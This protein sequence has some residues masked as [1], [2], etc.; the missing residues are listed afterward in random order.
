MQQMDIQYKITYPGARLKSPKELSPGTNL[1]H[2]NGGGTPRIPAPFCVKKAY[3]LPFH[4]QVISSL[5][6]ISENLWKSMSNLILPDSTQA[7]HFPAGRMPEMQQKKSFYKRLDTKQPTFKITRSFILSL[8]HKIAHTMKSVYSHMTTDANTMINMAWVNLFR[9]PF[10]LL[11][12]AIKK[13]TICS[14]K[15]EYIGSS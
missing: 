15:P 6:S 8:C 5:I 7:F 2:L 3:T 9:S 11:Q 13:A 4:S 12:N 10:S 14:G 1:P